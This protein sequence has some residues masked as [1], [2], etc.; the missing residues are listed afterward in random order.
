M[1]KYAFEK[2]VRECFQRL[3]S[4]IRRLRCLTLRMLD[5]WQDLKQQD[6]PRRLKSRLSKSP[7]IRQDTLPLK[8]WS[9]T[10]DILVFINDNWPLESLPYFQHCRICC[11]LGIILTCLSKNWIIF[12]QHQKVLVQFQRF[13]EHSFHRCHKS[14]STTWLIEQD[15]SV[16]AYLL[17]LL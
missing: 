7:W 5:S 2:E 9:V 14:K 10:I 17:P 13:E 3:G 4:M 12:C 1:R 11:D 15:F 16:V 8:H 6:D